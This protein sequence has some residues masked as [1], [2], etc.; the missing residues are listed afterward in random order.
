MLTKE[1]YMHI[2]TKHDRGVYQ[3]DIA[4]ELD[5]SPRTVSR[6][7]K[8]GSAPSGRRPLAK[9]SM[10]D[11][12][13]PMIDELLADDVWN[14][15]V[16]LDVIRERGYTDGE[17]LIRNYIRPKRPLRQSR[18]TVRFETDPGHQLQN[19]WGEIWSIVAGERQKLHFTV[20]TLGYSR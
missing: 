4:A 1:D 7:L 3:K 13:R 10:L 19:D 14:A 18:Q 20:S 17:T 8:R 16:I 5:V 6:A 9:T 2:K 15:M 12:F 11:P